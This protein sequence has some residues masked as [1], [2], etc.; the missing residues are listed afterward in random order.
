[1]SESA[2][3]HWTQY[4]T[5][6]HHPGW[7]REWSRGVRPPRRH[8]TRWSRCARSLGRWCSPPHAAHG[9]RKKQCHTGYKSLIGLNMLRDLTRLMENIFSLTEME[10]SVFLIRKP[11]SVE[12]FPH[13]GWVKPLA[14]RKTDQSQRAEWWMDTLTRLTLHGQ[15]L[16]CCGPSPDRGPG[17]SFLAWTWESQIGQRGASK[18]TEEAETGCREHMSAKKGEKKKNRRGNKMKNKEKQD[19]LVVKRSDR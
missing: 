11:P 15:L 3:Q 14:R 4:E 7:Q 17:P 8:K 2:W 18:D 6:Y 1:M 13:V 9:L 10:S 5:L 12:R 16:F 19:I